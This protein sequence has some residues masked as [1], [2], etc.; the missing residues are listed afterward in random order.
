MAASK[1]PGMV[2]KVK[3]AITGFF[4]PDEERKPL[5]RA[6]SAKKA[7]T[8]AKKATSPA[9]KVPA[10]KAPAKKA[11]TSMDRKL[12]ALSQP[13]EVRDWCKAF[14]CT[15]AELRSAVAAVGRSAAK[16]REYIKASKAPAKK[17][18]MSMDRKLIALSQPHEVR[19][20]C[21]SL[22]CTEAELRAA[23]GAVGRS[24]AKVRAHFLKV[25]SKE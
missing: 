7:S 8:A 15:E 14:G 25:G 24:A 10:K 16:A 2:E 22:G 21:K 5:K 1:K 17:A 12:I 20:W 13:H 9:K 18:G 6:A 23:V 11:G 4:S 19:D 3:D